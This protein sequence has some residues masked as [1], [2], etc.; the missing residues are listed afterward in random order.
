MN[1]ATCT[2]IRI[3]KLY[4]FILKVNLISNDII[5]NFRVGS[6]HDKEGE[7]SCP[8][9]DADESFFVMA[10]YVSLFT[11]RWSSCSRGFINSLFE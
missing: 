10:P 11:I 8:A 5:F 4:S 1:W 9:Q 7:S 6:S 2:L 3:L